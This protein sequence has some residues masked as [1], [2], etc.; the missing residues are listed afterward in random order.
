[1]ILRLAAPADVLRVTALETELFGPDA[2][3]EVSVRAELTG[4]GRRVVV[5]EAD[6]NDD[7]VVGYVVTAA[8]GDMVDL[9]RIAV[10]PPYR[11][12]GLARRLLD[13]V[14][15]S[16]PMLLE[17]SAANTGALAFYAAEGF[18]EI[19]RRRRYYRDG[20]DAVVMRRPGP[21][22]SA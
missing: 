22:E 4:R 21:A 15:P 20:T 19:S 10:A 5:A 3:S 1:M 17:V 18:A 8:A 9:Q 12:R 6:E 7:G 16:V 13:A 14:V 2:W 11:R